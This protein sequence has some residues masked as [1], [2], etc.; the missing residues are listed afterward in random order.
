MKVYCC[1]SAR[2]LL[3]LKRDLSRPPSTLRTCSNHESELESPSALSPTEPS[4]AETNGSLKTIFDK[5]KNTLSPTVTKRVTLEMVLDEKTRSSVTEQHRSSIS[6]QSGKDQR[7]SRLRPQKSVSFA[8]N[9]PKPTD[10]LDD[11]D[12]ILVNSHD[13]SATK[14]LLL[15]D[16]SDQDFQRDF[17]RAIK[18]RRVSIGNGRDLAYQDLS[19]EIVAYI[20]KHALR[21]VEQEDEE[22]RA[23]TEQ[24]TRVTANVEDDD[25]IDLK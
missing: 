13:G 2:P 25:F 6:S 19:A 10:A 8:E 22:L 7:N 3:A 12:P 17:H 4:E 5:V 20:L 1:L 15:D 18:P 23:L 9:V 11:V 21:T 24:Q 14:E 16:E